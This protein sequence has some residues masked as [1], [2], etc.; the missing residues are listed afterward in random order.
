M[1]HAQPGPKFMK[2]H[3]IETELIDSGPLKG[4]GRMGIIGDLLRATPSEIEISGF[5]AG[6]PPVIFRKVDKRIGIFSRTHEGKE[7]LY[8]IDLLSDGAAYEEGLSRLQQTQN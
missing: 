7:R 1:E 2:I 6:A 3:M 5:P 8:L 4:T